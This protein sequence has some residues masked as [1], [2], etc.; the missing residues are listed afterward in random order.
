MKKTS[1]KS[2]RL[3]ETAILII[4]LFYSMRMDLT[5]TLEAIKGRQKLAILKLQ[6]LTNLSRK[7]TKKE[8]RDLSQV[9]MIILVVI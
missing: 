1:E 5:D 7:S 3:L 4:L 9:Q 8:S 2:V 6:K